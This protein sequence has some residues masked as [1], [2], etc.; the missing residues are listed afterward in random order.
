MKQILLYVACLVILTACGGKETPYLGAS[1]DELIQQ[2]EILVDQS[3]CKTCH[4][5]TNK[6]IG[7]SHTDVAKRY[8]FTKDN[9]DLLADVIIKGGVGEWGEIQMTPHTDLSKEDAS[10][11]AYYILSL[12]GEKLQ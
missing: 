9:V 7:P 12:D 11:M 1:A 2:G 5:K 6:I 8:K 3:D 4:H 10:K